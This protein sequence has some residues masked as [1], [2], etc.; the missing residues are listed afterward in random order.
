MGYTDDTY[1]C[2]D[3]S[4]PT[5]PCA[6]MESLNTCT[7]SCDDGDDAS[8]GG[9]SDDDDEDDESKKN[10]EWQ[11]VA[12]AFIILFILA[13]IAIIVLAYFLSKKGS[14]KV[15]NATE[16]SRNGQVEV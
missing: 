4:T 11:G 13:V 14:E 7:G 2:V 15:A 1:T 5:D 8:G 10:G 16:A 3:M 9:S 6:T 12:I